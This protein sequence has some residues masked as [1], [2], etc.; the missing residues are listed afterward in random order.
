[1][2]SGNGLENG[3]KSS[4]GIFTQSNYNSKHK[5][6]VEYNLLKIHE[7]LYVFFIHK[8]LKKSFDQCLMQ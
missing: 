8:N 4:H 1:M 3:E 5:M 2:K 7:A 6:F